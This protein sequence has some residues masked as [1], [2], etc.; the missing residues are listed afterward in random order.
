M[1]KEILLKCIQFFSK[2]KIDE[3]DVKFPLEEYL[4]IGGYLDFEKY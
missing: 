2:V 4:A 3:N 1:D